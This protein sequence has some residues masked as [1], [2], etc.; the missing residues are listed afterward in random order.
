MQIEWNSQSTP[1]EIDVVVSALSGGLSYKRFHSHGTSFPF[2]TIIKTSDFLGISRI[3]HMICGAIML[4][5]SDTPHLPFN[6]DFI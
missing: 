1:L 5:E 4:C 6:S 2:P 3:L